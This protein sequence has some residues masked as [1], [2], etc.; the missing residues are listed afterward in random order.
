[1]FV[2]FLQLFWWSLVLAVCAHG[3]DATETST[4]P[5]SAAPI[6]TPAAA[7][8][9]PATSAPAKRPDV[10]VIPIREQI[11]TPAL[12]IVRRGLKEAIEQKADV[13]IFDM[14]TPGGALDVTKDIMEAIRKFPGL[15]L[16]Y[17]NDEAISAGSIIAASTDDIWLAPLGKIGAAAPVSATGQDIEKTMKGKVVSYLLADVRGICQA[18]GKPER[19]QVISAMIDEEF[20]LKIGEKVIKA[21]GA[22]PLTLT[23]AEAMET[24]GE[25]PQ[26]LLGAGIA[27]DIDDLLTQKYGAGNYNLKRLDANWSEQLAVWLNAIA[28]ILLGLGLLALFIEFK[29]PGFGIFGI[30]GITLLVIVFLSNYVAGFSGH[31]P[32]ILFAA[33]LLLVA[34]EIFVLPGTAILAVCGLIMMFGSLVWSMADLWPNEPIEITADTFVRPIVNVGLGCAIAV[35][36]GLLLARF[37]PK[38][39]FWDKMIVTSTVDAAA[40][41]SGTG[42]AIEQIHA[43]IGQTGVAATALRPSGQVEIAGRRYEARV[44]LGTLDAGTPVVVRG[45]N[46]FGLIVE[47]ANV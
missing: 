29:T 35:V 43:I 2:R 22:H 11:A 36:L 1:M 23:A 16:T 6:T 41:I 26:P 31:E 45:V 42:N 14:K 7:P 21:K 34:L 39:W 40:Q 13:V 20:E 18:K 4:P 46:D 28:P 25:P 27:K 5:P 47:K 10:V 3:A 9:A 15:T 12:Y 44:D 8:A 33:G 24:Y 37:I 38:G 32:M 17:V 19:G 30:S